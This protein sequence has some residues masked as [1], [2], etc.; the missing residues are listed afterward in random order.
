LNIKSVKAL[1]DIVSG[2]NLL[3]LHID[4]SSFI[5][6]GCIKSKQHQ[7]PFA[8]EAPTHATK[9]IEIVHP[10]LCGSIMTTSIGVKYFITSIDDFLK[11]I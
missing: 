10:H 9:L 6:K 11:K 2:L 7:L 1:C 5:Y 4:F 8:G 3:Q